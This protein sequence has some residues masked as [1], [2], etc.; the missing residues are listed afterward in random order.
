MQ[1]ENRPTV[2]I[3]FP[4]MNEAIIAH[5]AKAHKLITENLGLTPIEE[6]CTIDEENER[7][8][9]DDEYREYRVPMTIV[10]KSH[11]TVKSY[12]PK[13]AEEVVRVC[14]AWSDGLTEP[15]VQTEH[16]GKAVEA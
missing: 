4:I 10:Q 5:H 6:H 15:T 14:A 1:K 11:S 16:V 13:S 3:P 2:S 7:L 8:Y 12:D 9:S